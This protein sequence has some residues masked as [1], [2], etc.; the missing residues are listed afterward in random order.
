MALA[1]DGTK[2]KFLWV[3]AERPNGAAHFCVFVDS[4]GCHWKGMQLFKSGFRKLSE[5][6]AYNLYFTN[7]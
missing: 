3:E 7:N 2:F 5:E 1:L 6:S 4:R